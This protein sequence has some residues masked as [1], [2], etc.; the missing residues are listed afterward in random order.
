MNE[1]QRILRFQLEQVRH[2]KEQRLHQSTSRDD[3]LSQCIDSTTADPLNSERR[4][5]RIFGVREA[6]A[7]GFRSS[8]PK[9]EAARAPPLD[10][11]SDFTTERLRLVLEQAG[12]G[13]GD[14]CN[15]KVELFRAAA[16]E[17]Q[18]QAKIHGFDA[19][20]TSLQAAAF[21]VPGSTTF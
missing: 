17:L 4:H 3:I 5:R 8:S 19:E 2:M 16:A 11:L 21:W 6:P 7:P 18:G 20:G 10:R 13:P 15:S 1:Q 14:N 9:A 12:L